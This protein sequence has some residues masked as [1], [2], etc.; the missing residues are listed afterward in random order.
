MLETTLAEHA[1][2]A[3]EGSGSLISR[4]LFKDLFHRIG[5]QNARMREATEDILLQMAGYQRLIGPSVVLSYAT[6]VTIEAETKPKMAIGRL[7]LVHKLLE[8]HMH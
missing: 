5:D 3:F 1:E 6:K 2:I 7:Q 4:T 8:K